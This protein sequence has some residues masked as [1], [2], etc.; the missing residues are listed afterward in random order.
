[1][2]PTTWTCP[3]CAQTITANAV[4]VGHACPSRGD[5]LTDWTPT[6]LPTNSK[7]SNQ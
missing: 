1:M 5:R 4:A 3:G 7:G 6:D 2:T